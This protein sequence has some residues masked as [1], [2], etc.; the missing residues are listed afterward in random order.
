ME[1]FTQAVYVLKVLVI[2]VVAGLTNNVM[3]QMSKNKGIT[4]KNLE[5]I[6]KALDCTPNDVISFNEIEYQK[7]C[8][9]KLKYFVPKKVILLYYL[10]SIVFK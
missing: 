1:F 9:L 10:K 8:I 2:A 7:I 6:C 4:F 5:R 3:A